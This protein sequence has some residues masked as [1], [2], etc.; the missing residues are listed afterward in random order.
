M[1]QCVI[2]NRSRVEKTPQ[3]TIIYIYIIGFPL[4]GLVWSVLFFSVQSLSADADAAA[5][6]RAIFISN[7]EGIT[8]CGK[9]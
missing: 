7:C 3:Q 9:N 5:V 1:K 8:D 4:L 6:C 2:L